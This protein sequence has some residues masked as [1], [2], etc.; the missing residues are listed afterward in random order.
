[1][2][3]YFL[4]FQNKKFNYLIT[5]DSAIFNQSIAD[6]VIPPAYQAHSQ[7][8]YTQLIFDSQNSFLINL[9]TE[10]LLASIAVSIASSVANHLIFLSSSGKASLRDLTT[11]SGKQLS[12][13]PSFIHGLY[14]DFV[15]HNDLDS[16]HFKKS[17]TN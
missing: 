13:E 15:F 2:L 1:M 16:F 5:I 12:I 3:S 10:L 7:A 9:T 4:Y 8:G 17:Q 6:D 11:K 14:V